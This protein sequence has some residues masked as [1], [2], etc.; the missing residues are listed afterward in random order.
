MSSSGSVVSA[1]AVKPRRSQYTTTISRRRLFSGSSPLPSRIISASFGEK[2]R[3]RRESLSFSCTCS[4][5]RRSSVALHSAS[6]A[7][8]RCVSSCSRLIRSSDCTRANSSGW[9]IGLP[10]KSSAPAAMPLMRSCCGSSDVHSTT[11]RSAVAGSL[12][13]RRQTSYPDMPGIITSSSTRSGE[14]GGDLRE[15]FLAVGGGGDR[16]ALHAEKIGEELDVLRR[17]VDDE[18]AVHVAHRPSSVHHGGSLRGGH[19]HGTEFGGSAGK[20]AE[21][22]RAHPHIGLD[23]RAGRAREPDAG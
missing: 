1:N 21:L 5:T 15:R 4:A 18:N 3:F 19:T 13:R 7:A 12:R 8:W 16:I 9:L 23:A 10:R 6:C 2:K 14:L 11:G 17:V 20:L 22:E